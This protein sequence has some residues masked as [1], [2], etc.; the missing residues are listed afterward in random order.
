MKWKKHLW[1]SFWPEA[2]NQVSAH[3]DI[4]L[5]EHVVWQISRLLFSSW[6]SWYLLYSEPPC[7]PGFCSRGHR[8]LKK[9]LLEKF[10][11]GCLMHGHLWYLNEM[12]SAIQA[13]H[14]ALVSAQEDLEKDTV[15]STE[16]SCHGGTTQ[17]FCRLWVYNNQSNA[18]Q[19]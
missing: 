16:E 8:V 1:V 12:I 5:E 4:W 3:E 2:S 11:D 14:F 6:P 19:T 7:L 9:K 10:Q 18:L 13:L 17:W 15:R